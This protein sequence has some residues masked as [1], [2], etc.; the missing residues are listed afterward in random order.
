MLEK[1]RAR[2]NLLG[3][4]R[5]MKRFGIFLGQPGCR[6]KPQRT[7][8]GKDLDDN[9]ESLAFIGM[10]R[11]YASLRARFCPSAG[12]W[13]D[14]IANARKQISENEA[15]YMLFS[16][17]VVL[18]SGKSKLGFSTGDQKALIGPNG[19]FQSVCAVSP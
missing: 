14:L 13:R 1:D 9:C 7:S 16:H 17:S 10:Q 15:P 19:S 18:I 2:S 4:C 12:R 3:S 6:E 8:L 5:L 11:A